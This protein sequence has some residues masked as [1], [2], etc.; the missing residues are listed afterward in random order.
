MA[1]DSV[2]LTGQ[3]G[4]SAAGR[5]QDRAAVIE[6]ARSI[7]IVF[8]DGA[9]GVAGGVHAAELVVE[10]TRGWIAALQRAPDA[11][12]W[13]RW[14]V[15]LDE[16]ILADPLAG[17]ATA[18]C[19]SVTEQGIFGASVGNSEAWLVTASGVQV[20]TCRQRRK[21]LLGSGAAIP[22][23]FTTPCIAGRLLIG[24]DGLFRFAREEAVFRVASDD[25][26]QRAVRELVES[27]RL[28]SGEFWDDA[29]VVVCRIG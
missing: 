29:T 17:D 15:R 10:E 11:D 20:L 21:P 22:V 8:A 14:L 1:T 4:V 24:S 26:V 28:P 5:G 12:E 2:F 6:V 9:G 23:S 18:V 19:A 7:M 25:N 13:A 27:V 16:R 3:Y